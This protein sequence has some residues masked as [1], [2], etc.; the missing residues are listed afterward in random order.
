MVVDICC[1]RK[2]P[3]SLFVCLF[4]FA[5]FKAACLAYGSSQ[6]TGYNQRSSRQPT[7]NPQQS[8]IQAA[9]ANYRSPIL[10]P[11]NEARDQTLVFMD[12]SQ[13]HYHSATM[14][15]YPFFCIKEY[16]YNMT[17]ASLTCKLELRIPKTPCSQDADLRPKNHLPEETSYSWSCHLVI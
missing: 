10:K 1:S 6:A 12:T 4:V 7:A 17:P 14:G 15:T 5:F 9:P 11:L 13:V 3:M 2:Y 16:S 8:R